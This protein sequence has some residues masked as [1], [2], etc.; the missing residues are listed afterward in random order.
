MTDRPIPAAGWTYESAYTAGQ[1]SIRAALR[2]AFPDTAAP[3]LLSRCQECTHFLEIGQPVRRAGNDAYGNTLWA[4]T[5][6]P[7][8]DP[9][10][11]PAVTVPPRPDRAA[12]VQALRNVLDQAQVGNLSQ[13]DKFLADRYPELDP[14]RNE[15]PAEH[16][17]NT[18][19][20][21]CPNGPEHCP[22]HGPDGCA[23]HDTILITTPD[24]LK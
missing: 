14:L 23:S 13:Y 18:C 1:E 16:W 17:S 22:S 11:R 19:G 15:R 6:C 3:A 5:D 12:R 8:T 21:Q 7:D 20:C 10:P 4:H 2:V 9:E 24:D